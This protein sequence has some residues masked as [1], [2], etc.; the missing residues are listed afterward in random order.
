MIGSISKE[1]NHMINPDVKSLLDYEHEIDFLYG[2]QIGK[3]WRLFSTLMI[4]QQKRQAT[5][6]ELIEF[7]ELLFKRAPEIKDAIRNELSK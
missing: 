1:I 4:Y 7:T 2:M 5:Q 6:A 3:V